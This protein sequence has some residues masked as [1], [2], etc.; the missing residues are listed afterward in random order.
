MSNEEYQLLAIDGTYD[1]PRALM[2]VTR[3]GK[4][5]SLYQVDVYGYVL[6]PFSNDVSEEKP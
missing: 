5:S 3:N 4:P 1:I 2:L 6:S